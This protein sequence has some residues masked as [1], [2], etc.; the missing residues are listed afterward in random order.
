MNDQWS[1]PYL[2]VSHLGKPGDRRWATVCESAAGTELKLWVQGRGFEA[3]KHWYPGSGSVEIAKG[4][5]EDY[6]AGRLLG[7]EAVSS[8]IDEL[9]RLRNEGLLDSSNVTAGLARLLEE[10]ERDGR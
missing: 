6:V 7:S 10:F 5:G 3:D 2:G 8:I 4:A 9:R 1:K